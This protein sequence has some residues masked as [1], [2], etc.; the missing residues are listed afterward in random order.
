MLGRSERRSRLRR[1]DVADEL[2]A[3]RA[4]SLKAGAETMRRARQGLKISRLGAASLRSVNGERAMKV[5][6]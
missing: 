2:I 3:A 4:L 6:R 5:G 1:R